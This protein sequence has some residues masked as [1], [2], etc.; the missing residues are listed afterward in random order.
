MV[1]VKACVFPGQDRFDV[2]K[3]AAALSVAVIGELDVFVALKAGIFP[4]P[5]VASPI[6]ERSFVHVMFVVPLAEKFT[7]AVVWLLQIVCAAIG[8]STGVGFT[9]MENVCCGP[10]HVV[11]L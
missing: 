5:V 1:N 9:V 6:A 2:L 8:L 4:F 7:A 11:P 3:N 10:V